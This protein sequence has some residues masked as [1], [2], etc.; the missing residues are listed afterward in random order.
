MPLYAHLALR[1]LCGPIMGPHKGRP[2]RIHRSGGEW[3]CS[4]A[5]THM[6]THTY[7]YMLTARGVYVV[8]YPTLL[9][10]ANTTAFTTKSPT[11]P[12][13]HSFPVVTQQADASINISEIT[14]SN[15]TNVQSYELLSTAKSLTVMELSPAPSFFSSN[16]CATNCNSS[17]M[18]TMLQICHL[19]MQSRQ[20]S[21]V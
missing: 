13:L 17:K 9:E 12:G 5:V 15:Y 6:Y 10:W 11:T 2:F 16:T 14:Q 4:A 21:G 20:H 7:T 1:P 19:M 18:L 3:C 8:C